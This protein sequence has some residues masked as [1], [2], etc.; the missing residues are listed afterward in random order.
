MRVRSAACIALVA[1]GSLA[2]VGCEAPTPSSGPDSAQTAVDPPS[3]QASEATSAA[4]GSATLTWKA[5]TRKKNGAELK[6]L[7]GFRIYYGQDPAALTAHLDVPG[8]QTRTTTIGHLAK[9]TWYFA[10]AAYTTDGLESPMTSIVS[11]TVE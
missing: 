11:K 2:L 9:G 6:N 5:P 1:I 3:T 7:A 10:V 8:P 4:T